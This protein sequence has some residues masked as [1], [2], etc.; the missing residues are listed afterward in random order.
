M[1][2]GLAT[3]LVQRSYG[4]RD[5][6]RPGPR[7]ARRRD[8]D[9]SNSGPP[10]TRTAWGPSVRQTLHLVSDNPKTYKMF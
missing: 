1:R 3:C 6:C 7:S 5:S 9:R 4:S 10:P 2:I 8:A